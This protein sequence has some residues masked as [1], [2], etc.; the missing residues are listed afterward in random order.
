MSSDLPE[1]HYYQP[2]QPHHLAH[3]LRGPLNS[4]LGFTELLLEGIEG[5]L[6]DIQTEDLTAI[7]QSTQ[8]L[9]TLINAYVDLSRL[10]AGQLNLEADVINC[11]YAIERAI[12]ELSTVEASAGITFNA[13]FPEQLPPLLGDFGRTVQAI[14]LPAQF[15]ANRLGQG[16]IDISAVPGGDRVNII[17]SAAAVT[18]SSVQIAELFEQT[19]RVD[20][21]S[22]TRLSTGGIFLPL[23][24]HLALAQNGQ[25]SAA[26]SPETGTT[27]T[28]SLP[29][30]QAE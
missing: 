23:A 3:D 4:M 8:N 12:K 11:V 6:N 13:V 17:I 18:L 16:E 25:L 1:D 20:A 28:L 9:L 10:N 14:M 26:S 2:L 29:V 5:P 27:F 24:Y 15:L 30:L 21:T 22:R 7:W 19:V